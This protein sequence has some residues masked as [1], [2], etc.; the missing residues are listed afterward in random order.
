MLSDKTLESLVARLGQPVIRE[1]MVQAMRIM[2]LQFVLGR[3]IEEAMQRAKDYPKYRMSYDMLGEGA[4]TAEDAQRYY[5]SYR[6][7]IEYI[8]QNYERTPGVRVPGISVKLSALHPRYQVTQAAQCVPDLTA[9]LLE[10]SLLAKSYGMALTVDAEESERLEI[11][12]AIIEAALKDERLEGWDGF[13][14]AV[15]A[16]QKRCN[17]LIDR[18]AEMARRL[19]RKIQVRLV[20]GAYWD[21][22]IKY[23]QVEGFEGF[24]VFTRKVNTD[25]S[26]L[27]C[28]QKMLKNGDV[29]FPMFATHN[30]HTISA[31][32]DLARDYPETDFEFQ[33][34]HGMG[35]GLYD[36]VLKSN[37]V[38]A[39]VYAPVGPHSD[40][41][42]YL[43]RR[44]LENGANSS[45]VNKVMDQNLRAEDIVKD[46]VEAARRHDT[47]KHGAIKMP[48][49]LFGNRRNSIGIDLNDKAS[50]DTL[51]SAIAQ[52]KNTDYTVQSL[53]AKAV[54]GTKSS[55]EIKPIVSPSN[56]AHKLGTAQYLPEAVV[57][58]V[59]ASARTGF[60]AWTRTPAETR[61][62]ALE[63]YADL[64]DEHHAELM[65]LCV[66][67]AGKT[68]RDALLELREAVDF[69]RYYAE[70]GR[71]AFAAEGHALPG[72]TGESNILT[73]HG[74]GVFVCIS[75]W[76][77]PLAIFTGQVAAAL[78]AGNAVIA[79]PAEQT[80]AVAYRAVSLM[81]KAGIPREVLQLVL[82]DGR[83]GAALTAHKD[84]DGVAFTGSTEVAKII[85]RTLAAKDGAI[86]PLIAETGGQNAMIV[87]SSAL[88]EQ[89]IDTVLLSAFGST[90][91]RCSALRVLF[92]QEDVADK[93]LHMLSGAM[94]EL[95]LGD[96]YALSTDIGP[97]IDKDALDIL[98]RHKAWL[99]QNGRFVAEANLDKKLANIGHYIAPC[100]Y[101]ISDI[102]DLE[103]EI[104]GPILHVIRY[105]AQDID[106]VIAAINNSKYGLTLGVHSRIEA[107]QR[108]I[109]A[110]IRVGNAYV[111]RGMTGAVV[112]SQ[113]FGGCGLSGTGP[114]AGGPHYLYAY[115]TEKVTS[116]DTT[117]AGGNA[118]L[119]S[120]G[121]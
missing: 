18:V 20:K 107:F 103:R 52:F 70:Q 115:A 9:K 16:Y 88:P 14:L 6:Q 116:I 83:I 39:T 112:G 118:S 67:E 72:P 22:E 86:V 101:E 90:G 74:R 4:R 27:A 110:E 5:E 48:A 109:A 98:K 81:H 119:V 8:G 105:R 97:V 120:M 44:L 31:I 68:V 77:F 78:M 94:Q 58:Q 42:A 32:L 93:M 7:A 80:C 35:E 95:I 47:K 79:K 104:F 84:L 10:L 56:S 12:M 19:Q 92:V 29:F 15:Q 26:Y 21:R 114:K 34:L 55:E 38:N 59:Y 106:K 50:A 121:D 28:A 24:P 66:Y 111:N 100:A 40:L 61:A 46:P 60:E 117:A 36:L 53:T 64:M 65:A 51:L 23:A 11:S 13:G 45:F 62:R 87:D 49:D 89:V 3:S 96:P 69:C 71:K 108:K 41:L 25:L 99:A 75:P 57:D 43:V 1:A 85:Q 91:Q 82:G 2:G 73:H 30:A 33:R 102:S 113:P 54:L 17:L 76:N 37:H 63:K